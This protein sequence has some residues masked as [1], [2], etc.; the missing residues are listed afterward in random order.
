MRSIL[1]LSSFVIMMASGGCGDIY[2]TSSPPGADVYLKVG[3][4]T[5]DTKYVGQTP[6][7]KS[8]AGEYCAAYVVWPDGT[9]S[10][11]KSQYNP[12]F[13]QGARWHF[14]KPG[15]T[16]SPEDMKAPPAKPHPV[17]KSL[18]TKL[19]QNFSLAEHPETGLAILRINVKTSG[20][21]FIG[22]SPIQSHELDL[23]DSLSS[24]AKAKATRYSF[25]TKQLIAI[26]LLPGEHCLWRVRCGYGILGVAYP[27]IDFLPIESCFNIARG[28]VL[29]LGDLDIQYTTK[30]DAAVYGRYYRSDLKVT[31]QDGFESAIEEIQKTY[32]SL[33]AKPTKCLLSVTP[34]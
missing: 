16:S 30:A 15:C 20:P 13:G 32:P 3:H 10:E 7:A 19:S 6:Y 4:P 8:D 26:A 28:Q 27:D 34:H 24:E 1:L 31:I 11:W 33:S 2:I 23:T 25:S 18:P 22:R 14:V 21:G 5:F 9:K 17:Q 12:P 29:Y